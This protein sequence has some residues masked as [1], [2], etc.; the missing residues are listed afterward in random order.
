MSD[1]D[2]MQISL[3][4]LHDLQPPQ[5]MGVWL[6][7]ILSLHDPHQQDEQDEIVVDDEDDHD[8]DVVNMINT[9]T[10]LKRGA[11]SPISRLAFSPP[12]K[13]AKMRREG[14]CAFSST[15]T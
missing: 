7:N 10:V 3:Q 11:Q 6:I 13:I 8:N 9:I 14:K 12:G 15:R 4:S 5:S 2:P 1:W